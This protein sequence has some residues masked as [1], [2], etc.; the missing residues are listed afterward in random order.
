MS[1]RFVC[2]SE[3][4]AE[5]VVHLI[6]QM[7]RKTGRKSRKKLSLTNNYYKK[8]DNHE[9]RHDSEPFPLTAAGGGRGSGH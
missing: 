2:Y 1:C 4:A 9:I 3:Q 7:S 5:N 6:K 8:R